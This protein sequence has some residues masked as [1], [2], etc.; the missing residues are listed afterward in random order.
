MHNHHLKV[1][2]Y[3]AVLMLLVLISFA[4]QPGATTAGTRNAVEVLSIQKTGCPGKCP[5]YEARFYSN[6]RMLF[7]GTQHVKIT[8]TYEYIIPEVLVNNMLA[9]AREIKYFTFKERYPSAEAGR[10]ATITRV[11]ADGKDKTIT[12]QEGAPE[13]LSAFQESIHQE[14][15]AIITEQP[16]IPIKSKR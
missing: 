11:V 13:A 15:M 2:Y 9:K 7:E 10:Q 12:V 3:T 1:V 4:C 6:G 8:G 5:Q 14:I 16:G